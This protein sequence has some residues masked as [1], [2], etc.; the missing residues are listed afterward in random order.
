MRIANPAVTSDANSERI[1]TAACM[2]PTADRASLC[3][4]S[5][6]VLSVSFIEVAVITGRT[7]EYRGH[8][9]LAAFM[10]FVF[11]NVQFV[12]FSTPPLHFDAHISLRC[13]SPEGDG[14]A[15]YV[16]GAGSHRSCGSFCIHP[17]Q[18]RVLN[19]ER[20]PTAQELTRARAI[21]AA[22]DEARAKG[23]GSVEFEGKMLDE[24]IVKRSA[25]LLMLAERLHRV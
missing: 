17:I 8:G 6:T 1:N 4:E 13:L 7:D 24:P 25:Q 15:G 22:Y 14:V 3:A 20:T 21:I 12:T 23:R 5:A 19:E 2:I 9:G 10:R 11:I 16:S 18:V